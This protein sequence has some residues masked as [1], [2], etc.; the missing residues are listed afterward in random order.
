[1]RLHRICGVCDER[2]QRS[3]LLMERIGM[4]QEAV[5]REVEWV[6]GTWVSHVVY[7]MLRSEWESRQE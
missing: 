6:K 3:R 7:A 4:R 2:N 1:M 5:L